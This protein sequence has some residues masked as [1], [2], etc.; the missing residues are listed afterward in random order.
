MGSLPTESEKRRAELWALLSGRDE[1]VTGNELAT[2]LQV[3][4]QVIVQD[5]ALL[6]AQGKAIIATPRGYLSLPTE[7]TPKPRRTIA[8]KHGRELEV[9]EKEL[10]AIVDEGGHVLDVIVEH[11]FYGELRGILMLQSRRDVRQFLHSMKATGAEPLSTLTEG[12]HLHTIEAH[13]ERDLD[14]IEQVLGKLGFTEPNWGVEGG[15]SL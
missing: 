15:P 6:R 1:P 2:R 5:V 4:R 3:S 7:A 10:T 14:Q 13:T 9:I 11:P 12:V 8:V